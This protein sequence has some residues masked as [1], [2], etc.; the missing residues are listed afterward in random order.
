MTVRTVTAARPFFAG[1][2]AIARAQL[3]PVT[4]P[5]TSAAGDC[6]SSSWWPVQPIASSQ[7]STSTVP[8]SRPKIR[9]FS[10][11]AAPRGPTP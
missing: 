3:R 6:S 10:N 4:L 2:A 9:S 5:G 1:S 11:S 8:R 7:C